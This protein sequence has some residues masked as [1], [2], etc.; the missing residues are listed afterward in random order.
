M[1]SS[2][3]LW[4]TA[5]GAVAAIA[6]RAS[7]PSGIF[8]CVDHADCP[9]GMHCASD[10]TCYR[11]VPEGSSAKDPISQLAGASGR[12]ERSRPDDNAAGARRPGAMNAVAPVPAGNGAARGG[13]GGVPSAMPNAAGAESPAP[14][15]SAVATV[16]EA[17]STPDEHACS[18]NQASAVLRCD[19]MRWTFERVCPGGQGVHCDPGPRPGGGR[20]RY[21]TPSCSEID[22]GTLMCIGGHV[23]ACE[24]GGTSVLAQACEGDSPHCEGGRCSC[25]TLCNGAC[26]SFNTDNKNCGKCG[27]DCYDGYCSMGVC[28][29]AVIVEETAFVTA[30]AIEG[31]SLLWLTRNGSLKR[32]L[33][34]APDPVELAQLPPGENGSFLLADGE[35]VFV[36][37][38]ILGSVTRVP[39]AGGSPAPVVTGET[40]LM[41]AVLDAEY[42]Y[43]IGGTNGTIYR[44]PKAG[45]TAVALANDVGAQHLVESGSY[46]YYGGN[47]PRLYRLPKEGG[48]APTPIALETRAHRLALADGYVY[49]DTNL[50]LR[51]IA[52]AGGA[53]T[54]V[55]AAA[56]QCTNFRVYGAYLFCSDGTT[57]TRYLLSDSRQH[58]VA[59]TGG[60]SI[61]SFVVDAQFVYAADGVRIL[62]SRDR[63]E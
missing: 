55:L 5:I 26:T 20:C 38:P 42:V 8:A 6:C 56:I 14:S 18:S 10:A 59:L 46:L 45:G 2:I 63:P 53:E 43:W 1:T 54:T 21:V 29:P 30:L 3:G 13:E 15:G 37:D 51:R 41:D 24:A 57:V 48:G 35:Q 39:L 34:T 32:T 61:S 49:Y 22:A 9:R 40:Q 50:G 58:T 60:G 4:L 25:R 52:T 12:D 17:C 16:G 31:Y 27:N 11:G 36:V 23:H 19:G 33:A 62:R 7:P 28:Q 44:S 47:Y